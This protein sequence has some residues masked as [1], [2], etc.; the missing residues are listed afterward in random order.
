MTYLEIPYGSESLGVDV[1]DDAQVQVVTPRPSRS[2]RDIESAVV[3]ALD[4]PVG[5]PSFRRLLSAGKKVALLVDNYARPTP[6][7]AILPQILELIAESRAEARILVANG[8][9]RP[10]TDEEL[11]EKLGEK[12]LNSG[13]PVTQS[14]AKRREDFTFIGVTSYGTPVEVHRIYLEADVRLGVHTTQMTL[15]G[16]GGGGSILLPG[17]SS[18]ETIEWNHRLAL[19]PGSIQPGYVGPENHLRNDIEEAA[20]LAG[21]DM[22]LNT[23]LNTDGEVVDLVAGASSRSHRAS[24]ERF[25]RIYSYRLRWPEKADISISGSLKW[26]KYMAHACWP[27]STLDPVTKD[28]GTII[29]ATPSPGGLA[30]L[31]YISGYMPANRES[32]KRLLSD[33]FERRQEL[34]HAML[35]YPIHLVLQRKKVIVVTGE[36]NAATLRGIGIDSTDSLDEAYRLAL[37]RS[38]K[39][40]RV[41]VAP[42]GKWMKPS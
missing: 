37:A 39:K 23:V 5:A 32:W 24:I 40:P 42:Y 33:I 13:V 7:Y 15:W 17:V 4:R 21:L 14:V 35:W 34:W 22:V 38:P 1:S 25:D 10:A 12:I 20:E 36:E 26:D 41:L 19:S 6:A 9:L 16:Y 3:K 2:L 27:I 11:N 8:G 30:H 28:S 18:F 29:L 31:S